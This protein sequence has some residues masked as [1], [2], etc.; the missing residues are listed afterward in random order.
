MELHDLLW[1]L[2]G[3][4]SG[5]GLCRWLWPRTIINTITHERVVEVKAPV[6]NTYTPP[7]HTASPSRVSVMFK[8]ADGTKQR[9]TLFRHSLTENTVWA[10]KNFSL[11]KI[12]PNLMIYTE[13]ING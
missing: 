4:L 10:G 6:E 3:L 7:L 13:H 11:T 2:S 9:K 12:K 8:F 5:V 1:S